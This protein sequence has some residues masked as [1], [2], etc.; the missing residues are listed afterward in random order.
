MRPPAHLVLSDGRIFR[1]EGAGALHSVITGEVVFNTTMTGYQEVISDPSYAGQIVA[2]T[3]TQIGNYGV[4]PSDDEAERPVAR[5]VVVCDL[6]RR[7][8]NWRAVES[9]SEFCERHGLFILS[10]VDT[11]A[12]TRHIREHGALAGAMG[13]GPLHRLEEAAHSAKGTDGEAL[14]LD[15]SAKAPYVVGEGPAH[16]VA[17]DFGIKRTI[18][19]HL[20]RR[21]KVTVVPA[22]TSAE[23]IRA[24]KADGIF[25]SNGPGDPRV[26]TGPVETIRSLLGEIPL[27]GICL[28]HQL[29][30][31][32]LGGSTYK[33]A[34]GHHGGN[35]PVKR[36]SDGVVEITAQNHNYAV[37]EVA[38]AA[39]THVNLND[40]VIEGIAISKLRAFSVQ[41]HPEAGPGPHD[42]LYLFDQFFEMVS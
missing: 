28:G 1:G 36:L 33:L 6:A 17:M 38:G 14:A 20:A 16:I 4:C 24:F 25:L 3:A 32:A 19:S 8:S 15:V 18:L 41:Y 37:G 42:A 30:A 23:E 22:S 7:V 31:Q 26:L 5:G 12:L 40:D 13:V 21:A 27:F 34:F 11:R 2:F 9:L 35:H 39:V 29:L 10:G